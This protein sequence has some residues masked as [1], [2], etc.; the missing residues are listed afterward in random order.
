[1]NKVVF[2]RDV[3]GER[4]WINSKF[5]G[6]TNLE[7]IHSGK[8]FSNDSSTAIY[9]IPY[10]D[11]F[12][13]DIDFKNIETYKS[14]Y[15]ADEDIILI[16]RNWCNASNLLYDITFSTFQDLPNEFVQT[17]TFSRAGTEFVESLLSQH[18]KTLFYHYRINIESKNTNMLN[19]LKNKTDITIALVYRNNW[20][21]WA[22]SNIIGRQYGQVHYDNNILG[23]DFAI[24]ISLSDIDFATLE[25]EIIHTWSFW[26]SLRNIFPQ[27]D[28][29]LLEF[30]DNI[31]RYSSKTSHSRVLYDKTKLIANYQETKEKFEL[32]FL[33]RW[34]I[35]EHNS[36]KHLLEMGCKTNLD[37][38]I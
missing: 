13:S 12:S 29:Y 9:E 11:E 17:F 37:N 28:F 25:T 5:P 22:I 8:W 19:I 3:D 21:E 6:Y 7:T 26:C 30:S 36:V 24:P 14:L 10:S 23:W 1:M 27:H 18:Y 31:K 2:T 20:W 34:K 4:D 33:P 38:F 32:Q 16:D 15:P 35:M